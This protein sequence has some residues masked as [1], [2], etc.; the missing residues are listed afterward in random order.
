MQ[1][2]T[3]YANTDDASRSAL[4]EVL[5]AHFR[6]L[7]ACDRYKGSAALVEPR[8]KRLAA[9]LSASQIRALFGEELAHIN[10][11]TFRTL[12]ERIDW[13]LPLSILETGSSAHGTNSSALFAKVIARFGGRFT[14]VD[15]NPMVSAHARKILQAHGASDCAAVCDDSVRFISSATDRYNV[16]YLDSFDLLPGRFVDSER[17][18]AAE[19]HGLIS[20]GLLQD[21]ALI[22]VD[23]TPRSIEILATQVDDAHLLAA[24]EHV[25]QHGRL[26]GKGA[27][28]REQAAASE[29]FEI[30]SWEYQLLLRYRAPTSRA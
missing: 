25:V 18:G 8:L 23:D 6:G 4:L 19:F 30:V 9:G 3:V 10:Y 22:L 2:A 28:I 11:P 7:A 16:V 12:F 17:H 26:P 21:G 14:T 1:G 20:R 15:L 27:L 5:E 13:P 24:R 29:S